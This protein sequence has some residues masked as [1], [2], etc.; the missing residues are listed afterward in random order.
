MDEMTEEMKKGPKGPVHA[1]IWRKL[2]P[3]NNDHGPA[4]AGFFHSE[5]AFFPLAATAAKRFLEKTAREHFRQ[6]FTMFFV[7][8]S[9]A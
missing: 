6:S 9:Q 1:V 2:S 4:A 7:A 5:A 8:S 3:S